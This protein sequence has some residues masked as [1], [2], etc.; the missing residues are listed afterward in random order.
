MDQFRHARKVVR[1]DQDSARASEK[2][3]D[4]IIAMPLFTS[5]ACLGTPNL[6]FFELV[7]YACAGV[8]D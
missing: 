1:L 8:S 6:I 5:T 4:A 3:K 7:I 2:E